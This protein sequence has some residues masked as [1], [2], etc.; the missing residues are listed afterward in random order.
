MTINLDSQQ[1]KL[2]RK[3][4]EEHTGKTRLELAQIDDNASYV[5][6][7]QKTKYN[8]GGDNPN[9]KVIY[10]RYKIKLF[11]EDDGKFVPTGGFAWA[12]P[13]YHTSGLRGESTGNQILPRG[14]YVYVY[15]DT[16][17]EEY[18]ID[19]V[20][21]NT[22]SD[23]QIQKTT[24]YE[25]V[26]GFDL[27]TQ[28]FLIPNTLYNEAWTGYA[29][30]SGK[31]FGEIYNYTDASLFDW[32]QDSFALDPDIV[33]P[34]VKGKDNSDNSVVGI[35]KA[36]EGVIKNIDLLKAKLLNFNQSL[37]FDEF[38]N[39]RGT[40]ADGIPIG[41]ST[42]GLGGLLRVGI[43]NLN[44]AQESLDSF[45]DEINK[46]AKQMAE[47]IKEIVENVKEK[48]LA[49]FNSIW[50]AVKGAFP[51]TGRFKQNE[52]IS[53]I[54]KGISCAFNLLIANLGDLVRNAIEAV[55]DKIVNV[56]SCLIENFVGTFIG[57]IVGQISA[58]IQG[59]L[60]GIT[61]IMSKLS[62]FALAGV[63]FLNAIGDVLESIL[64][65]LRCEFTQGGPEEA[66]AWN[67]ID[68]GK[69]NKIKIDIKSV[70]DKAKKVGQK[71]RDITNVPDD[72]ENY[73]FFFDPQDAL[74]TA[75]DITGKECDTGPLLCGLPDVLFW[76][77][78]G[79][80]ATGNA[81]V[82][83][84]GSLFSVDIILPG[85]YSSAPNVEF[86]DRCG[87]GRGG[88][89]DVSIG[90]T[91][92]IGTGIGTTNVGT[93]TTIGAG[94]TGGELTGGQFGQ[95]SGTGIGVTFIVTVKKTSGGNKYVVDGRQQRVLTFIR[96]NTY[97]FD[98]Q[99]ETNKTHQLR[100]S[101]TDNGTW[102]GGVEYE[103][104]VTID[105]IPGTEI[106][107]SRIIVNNNTPN[108]L[109]YYCINHS[110][111]GAK[112]NVIDDPDFVGF[113]RNGKNATIEI[114][115]VDASGGALTLK[116]LVGGSGYVAGSTNQSTTGGSGSGLTLDIETVDAGGITLLSINNKGSSYEVGDIVNII[117]SV[118]TDTEDT[119]VGVTKVVIRDGGY[120]Y[121]FRP[122]GSTGGMNR[123]W[124]NRCQT[125]VQRRNGDWVRF[126]YNDIII[127]YYGDCIQ[128]PGKPR[129]CIDDGFNENDLPGCTITGIGSTGGIV[130]NDMKNFPVGLNTNGDRTVDFTNIVLIDERWDWEK[131]GVEQ[132]DTNPNDNSVLDDEWKFRYNNETV[133]TF[134]QTSLTEIPQI[135]DEENNIL[136]RVG[137][138]KDDP[139]I[140]PI[141]QQTPWV[142]SADNLPRGVEGLWS[143][144]MKNYA[145][146][147]SNTKALIGSHTATWE[148]QASYA[149]KYSIEIQADNKATV[150]WDGVQLAE[151]TEF[152]SHNTSVFAAYAG[153]VEPGIHQVTVTIENLLHPTA[154]YQNNWEDNPAG[155]AF[156]V[157]DPYN[158]IIKSSLDPYPV[159]NKVS[160]ETFYSI[161][162]YN[163]LNKNRSNNGD[164]DL[165]FGYTKDYTRA[166][167]LGYTDADIRNFLANNTNGKG[168]NLNLDDIMKD[169]MDDEDWGTFGNGNIAVTLSAPACPPII[170]EDRDD[171]DFP[172]PTY[173]LI[174]TLDEIVIDNEGF[175]YDPVND[176][177]EI[178]PD[179]GAQ[180]VISRSDGRIQNITVTRPGAGFTSMP[181]V[182][183]NT[184]TGYNAV[185]IPVI[186]CLRPDQ[187][188]DADP[189]TPVVQVVDC[190]GN[191]GPA[192]RT[193]VR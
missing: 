43:G 69:P 101:E 130:L 145:V 33:I 60:G 56:T 88:W 74:D 15:M 75:V 52:I 91:T 153:D 118:D 100:F 93:G 95:G 146:Y 85:E 104:G 2:I 62:G 188:P 135:Y 186:K 110:G 99:D 108:T 5:E 182:R 136:Y 64:S 185:L 187:I 82:D 37:G 120:G 164:G 113:N 141:A 26:S 63:D 161:L 34:T 159:A 125:V 105:G 97:I 148:V 174:C 67:P 169:L 158:Q 165:Y 181:D 68:G 21:P 44:A 24:K 162:S 22:I 184:S 191:V 140:D 171:T 46:G 27:T 42:T 80:G 160:A 66:S 173:P 189:E 166:K 152:Q 45:Q 98:Q 163:V 16:D 59:V 123:T 38:G 178:I 61:G 31:N 129:V 96:G 10:P 50:N 47:W 102:N 193:T 150:S 48:L 156:V 73:K 180:A 131:F 83:T 30:L 77:G 132:T 86:D 115:T 53:I 55:F 13:Q 11:T 94:T 90:K 167:F 149:G 176:T 18:F 12:Y 134:T 79:S 170:P 3:L 177:V 78:N 157:R 122:D 92:R 19:R 6:T 147:P 87:R 116:N 151:T 138:L 20:V 71:F 190:V 58:L 109:Y 14:S 84:A 179:N 142:R 133:G 54:L 144:F 103:R 7:L 114:E 9:P 124:A 40:G 106:A 111:M 128:L 154:G 57:Q 41:L 143:P 76:G 155:V 70:F 192:A 65:L 126:N 36:F 175:G 127:L 23:P 112:I 29:N 32:N 49:Q 172:T 35:G 117:S 28:A 119:V 139:R 72:I 39:P 168:K 17:T 183:I 25:P 81:I 137:N 8:D 89:G 121:M 4:I 51:A 107:Y 1:V